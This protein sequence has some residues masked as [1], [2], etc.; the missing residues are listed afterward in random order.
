[1]TLVDVAFCH[2]PL[3]H[4]MIG[5]SNNVCLCAFHETYSINGVPACANRKLL[6]DILRKE[7]GFN[8]Y[9]ISDEA[10]IENI[11]VYHHY[12]SSIVDTVAAA[13]NA[14]KFYA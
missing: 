1:M 2:K 12:T 8:G 7:W 4:Y 5:F 6:T 3:L 9:V 11:F 14:G 13:V 10:A